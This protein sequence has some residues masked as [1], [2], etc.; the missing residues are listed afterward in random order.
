MKSAYID[1][2]EK[3]LSAYSK[4]EID[5]FIA[6][7]EKEGI[8]EHGFPRLTANIGILLSFGKSLEL[9]ATF[10]KMMDICCYECPRKKAANDFS[11][12]ELCS[13]IMFLE[14]SD[15]IEREKLEEW[16]E[17]LRQFDPWKYY[18]VV[19]ET[20]QTSVHNWAAFGAAS[21][22][23]RGI[24]CNVDTS[25]FVD[26]QV[27]TQLLSFDSMG[28]YKDPHNPITYDVVTRLLLGTIL[29]LGYDGE[30]KAQIL[31][32]LLQ[33]ADITLKMQSV[34]GEFP[35]GGRSNQ[36]LFNEA[37]FAAICECY[38]VIFKKQNDTETA[39]K[40]KAAAKKA[41]DLLTEEL[42]ETPICHV[43][44]KYPRYSQM[45]C[46]FYAYFDKYMITT[47][48]FTLLAYILA[49]DTI[50]PC[51]TPENQ[52]YIAKTSPDF[53]KLFLCHSNYFLQLD[54]NADFSYD[55][56][57]LGRL[58]KKGCNQRICLSVP[59]PP[60][61]ANY[62][63]ELK[64]SRPMSL[65]CYAEVDGEVLYG[66]DSCAQYEL[67]EHSIGA[68]ALF[69]SFKVALGEKLCLTESYSIAEDGVT[70]SLSNC[71]N[72]GFMLPCFYFDGKDYAQI[73]ENQNNIRVEYDGSLCEYSFSGEI[74]SS[75]IYCNRNGQYKV[76]QISANKVKIKLEKL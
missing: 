63:T 71:Y 6:R 27:A 2:I 48:S 26:R 40:F 73:T 10:V 52:G 37:F 65:C 34:T 69:A 8:T 9:K 30:Y 3:S 72:C 46:E 22:Y 50:E 51:K 19:A 67:E 39:A 44:N 74:K 13:A 64:N 31:D 42:K 53:H 20:P 17:A 5:R 43:K 38:A 75:E 1:I 33:S 59:F 54:T 16:R 49:D 25:E 7:V 4:E 35:Y 23:F 18:D 68:D 56:N 60:C 76:Y 36:F 24:C 41:A 58:H 15:V 70:I 61:P 28:M 12:R 47:A 29:C 14:K 11:I 32:K 62:D 66:S 57:G 45:G 21:D 55:A